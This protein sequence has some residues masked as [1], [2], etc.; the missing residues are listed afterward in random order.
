M[1]QLQLIRK[2]SLQG[3]YLSKQ[4]CHSTMSTKTSNKHHETV[5]ST[6]LQEL[7]T[8]LINSVSNFICPFYLEI[9]ARST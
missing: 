8:L 9:E 7:K 1:E 3:V 5:L 2:L 4:D 6:I